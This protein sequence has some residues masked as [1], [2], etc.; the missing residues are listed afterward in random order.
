[1]ITPYTAFKA[2]WT[3]TSNKFEVDWFFKTLSDRVPAA[4]VGRYLKSLKKM[5]RNSSWNYNFAYVEPV[6]D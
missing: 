6:T 5:N 1:V 3:S 4:N 2:R